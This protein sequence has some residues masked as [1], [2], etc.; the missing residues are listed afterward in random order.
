MLVLTG[1]GILLFWRK[2]LNA[3]LQGYYW[4]Y[5]LGLFLNIIVLT[6]LVLVMLSPGTIKAIF[7]KTEKILVYFRFWKKSD[8]RKNKINQF[9]SGYQ[10]T[11]HF[12]KNHKKMIA[13][14]MIG[15]F[16]Q[17]FSMFLLTYVIYYGLGLQGFTMWDIVWLQASVCITVDMLPVPGAQGITEAVSRRVFKN[18]FT[19]QYVVFSICIIRG[20]SFYLMMVLS[21][22]VFSADCQ[23]SHNK[24]GKIK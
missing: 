20:I 9:I 24:H 15:T 22:A 5:F 16:L 3:Y 17:R 18:I 7:F 6:A 12:L 21:L 11:V 8:V 4:L 2:S 19:G 10:E 14:V 13:A 1:I 23:D